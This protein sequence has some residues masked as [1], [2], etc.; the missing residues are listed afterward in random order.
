MIPKKEQTFIQW[1]RSVFDISENT[2]NLNVEEWRQE[3]ISTLITIILVILFPIAGILSSVKYVAEGNFVPVF[4]DIAFYLL[5]LYHFVSRGRS[6]L[7]FPIVWMIVLYTL[8]II[9][10]YNL[11]PIGARPAWFMTASIFFTLFYGMKAIPYTLAINLIILYSTY[12]IWAPNLEAWQGVLSFGL[13]WFV[14]FTVNLTILILVVSFSMGFLLN[15]LNQAILSGR[16]MAVD[17]QV[18]KNNLSMVN[19]ALQDEIKRGDLEKNARVESEIN[20]KQL[21]SSTMNG[22]GIIGLNGIFDDANPALCTMLGYSFKELKTIHYEKLLLEKYRVSINQKKNKLLKGIASNKN[23]Y[24]ECRRKDGSFFPAIMKAWL[25]YD[26]KSVAIGIGFFLNDITIEEKLSKERDLL[27][28]QLFQNQKS[29]AIG[30]LASGIAHDIN[31]IIS[32]IYGYTELT[33]DIMADDPEKGK[34]YLN[35][36]LAASDRARDIVQQILHFSRKE[37]KEFQP[38][39]V[40][41]L[42][43]EVIKLLKSTLP[44][45]IVI[46]IDIKT[47]KDIILADAAQ[48]HQVVMNLCTNA[49]QAMKAKGGN[50]SIILNNITINEPLSRKG[51]SIPLGNYLQLRVIDTGIG[52]SLKLIDR[53][54]DPYYTTKDRG[55]GTGLGLSVSS[56]IINNHNGFIEVLSTPGEGS[57]FILKIPLLTKKMDDEKKEKEIIP[58]GKGRKICIIDDEMALLNILSQ[59]LSRVDFVTIPFDNPLKAEKYLEE[60]YEEIDLILTDYNMPG[61][62]GIDL[63][64]HLHEKLKSPPPIIMITGFSDNIDK[65]NFSEYGLAGLIGKPITRQELYKGVLKVLDH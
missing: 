55:E 19:F 51:K 9:F 40:I 11:G 26:K 64:K 15:R 35:E 46:D 31:N 22:I 57:E 13:L 6:F 41:P 65:D 32:G 14:M 20:Y 23:E 1:L 34:E 44:A 27:E 48:I 50:L 33:Q 56:A 25:I 36:V 42:I 59:Y 24:I 18:E 43:K 54:F 49:Y 4:V 5:V 60:N 58:E 37:T 12:F 29:G 47:D 52:I 45:S 17:L 38:L 10:T 61:I 3:L 21:F 30:T 39:H 63:V 2:K 28:N 16:K 53:I 7:R 8:I 62:M